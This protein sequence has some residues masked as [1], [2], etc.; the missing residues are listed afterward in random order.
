MIHINP[1][2]PKSVS[3]VQK[4]DN[5]KSAE[6]AKA[7]IARLSR[8]EVIAAGE[9][10]AANYRLEK[11]T[12]ALK[13]SEIAY[14]TAVEKSLNTVEALRSAYNN[15]LAGHRDADN[16]VRSTTENLSLTKSALA[17]VLAV[18]KGQIANRYGEMVD[19]DSTTPKAND[20]TKID[21]IVPVPPRMIPNKRGQMVPDFSLEKRKFSAEKR[22]AL[23]AQGKALPD[24]S[25]PIENRTDLANAVQAVGRANNVAQVKAHIVTQAK[26]LGATDALP[27]EWSEGQNMSKSITK[28][29]VLILCPACMS[30]DDKG[31]AL[32]AGMNDGMVP[33]SWATGNEDNDYEDSSAPSGDVMAKAFSTDSLLTRDFEKS[34]GFQ[35]WKGGPG[36]GAQP[37]HPFNGNQHTGGIKAG[38]NLMHER[39]GWKKT[40]DRYNEAGQAL[41]KQGDINV[42]EGDR[43]IMRG[44]HQTAS[45]NFREAAK[46]YMKA[47]GTAKGAE[48]ILRAKADEGH[49][50]ASHTE[51]NMHQ[52]N[53][54]TLRTLSAGATAKA[55]AADRAA[56]GAA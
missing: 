35:I 40:I 52:E 19:D 7:Q 54:R 45:S 8:E 9:A 15:A 37:G 33:Q 42:R 22:Q 43:A 5:S 1:N 46:A 10:A 12:E 51:A 31:C 14:F 32:C 48:M 18:S 16:L 11:A 17:G 38:A 27:A 3:F 49:P 13:V 44:D 36:S 50:D 34:A 6:I 30:G 41:R 55:D 39:E 24:G 26:K 47:Q 21:D 4:S 28:S 20:T 25:Y 23:A 2:E 56:G 29:A 53:A